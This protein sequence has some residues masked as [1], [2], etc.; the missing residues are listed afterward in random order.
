MS[1]DELV[2]FTVHN[3]MQ[4]ILTNEIRE[5][6]VRELG[7]HIKGDLETLFRHTVSQI[8]DLTEI[9]IKLLFAITEITTRLEEENVR[10]DGQSQKRV[11][12]SR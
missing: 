7:P 8:L 11:D 10:I 1:A 12:D 9:E 3:D 4:K 5:E 6:L 2:E